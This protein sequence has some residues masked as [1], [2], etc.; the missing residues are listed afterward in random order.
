MKN[1][2]E[3]SP[4]IVHWDNTSSFEEILLNMTS[5]RALNTQSQEHLKWSI[6]K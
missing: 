2:H 3:Y 5:P 4:R 1:F 6:R